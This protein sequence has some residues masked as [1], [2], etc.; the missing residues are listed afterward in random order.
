VIWDP[1][2][3]AWRNGCREQGAA[4]AP[5]RGVRGRNQDFAPTLSLPALAFHPLPHGSRLR[6][7]VAQTCIRGAGS[8]SH[9]PAALTCTAA[10]LCC[11]RSSSRVAKAVRPGA[12]PPLS[13][14]RRHRR[15][16]S[17]KSSRLR[18]RWSL[19]ATRQSPGEVEPPRIR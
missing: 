10:A 4:G 14:G 5:R 1:D 19:A 18:P 7:E 16:H 9:G 6:V 17:V 12:L 15:G 13:A 11:L 3:R 8:A 2:G